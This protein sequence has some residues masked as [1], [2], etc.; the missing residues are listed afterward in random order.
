MNKTHIEINNEDE[1]M[2]VLRNKKTVYGLITI[3]YKKEYWYPSLV[4][5]TPPTLDIVVIGKDQPELLIK[6]LEEK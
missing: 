3:S 1:H 4:V 2:I 5:E 6:L